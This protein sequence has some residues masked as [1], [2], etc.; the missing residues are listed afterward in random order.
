M[1]RK[2]EKKT[3]IDLPQQRPRK[4]NGCIELN[5]EEKRGQVNERI[6]TYMQKKDI[7]SR[8]TKY[9]Q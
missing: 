5:G 1:K 4:K 7:K 6:E 2:K 8:K 3:I 9:T